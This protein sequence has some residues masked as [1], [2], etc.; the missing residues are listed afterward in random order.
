MKHKEYELLKLKAVIAPHQSQWPTE[1]RHWQLMHAAADAA[2][3]AVFGC[4]PKERR[5]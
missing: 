3:N 4:H 2:R 1:Y 5:D